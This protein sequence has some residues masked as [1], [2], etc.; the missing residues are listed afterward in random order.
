MDN[1]LPYIPIDDE[2]YLNLSLM[3]LIIYRMALTSRGN[4][5]LD[6]EK[7]QIFLYLLKNPSSINSILMQAKKKPAIFSDKHINTIQSQSANVDTLFDREKVKSLLKELAARG[8]IACHVASK[9]GSIMYQLT[10]KGKE[11][12]ES[13]LYDYDSADDHNLA[14]NYNSTYLNS[15]NIII[16][17]MQ[18]LQTQSNSKLNKYLKTYFKEQ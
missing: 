6:F 2:F 4:Y 3:A 16:D 11:F 15:I 8:F 17:G 12:S 1:N 18:A 5:T 7:I 14:T 10:A 9:T 13:L